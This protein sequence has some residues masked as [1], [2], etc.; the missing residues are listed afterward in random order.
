MTFLHKYLK[1]KKKYL[2][3]KKIIQKGGVF[4]KDGKRMV[5][6][7]TETNYEVQE[8]K[9]KLE[10]KGLIG[11]EAIKKYKGKPGEKDD[12]AEQTGK[13]GVKTFFEAGYTFQE[14]KDGGFN[15]NNFINS[16]ILNPKTISGYTF[17]WNDIKN[18]LKY[19]NNFKKL[20]DFGFEP[21]ALENLIKKNE[22]EFAKIL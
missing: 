8:L 7:D 18:T 15:I 13:I 5:R 10:E 3:L 16:G 21:V 1:Y 2:N 12:K 6:I 20:L 14:L 22:D 9:C 11:A 4:E 19:D 17:D